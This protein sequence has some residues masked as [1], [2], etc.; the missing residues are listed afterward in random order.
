MKVEVVEVV[1]GVEAQAAQSAAVGLNSQRLHYFHRHM[2]QA[3]KA[4]ETRCQ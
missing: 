1:E 4:L 2:L 3:S